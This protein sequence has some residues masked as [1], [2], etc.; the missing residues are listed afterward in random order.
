MH[1]TH[2]KQPANWRC[3]ECGKGTVSSTQRSH[4][5]RATKRTV[6]ANLQPYGHGLR[7]CTR[8]IK[9]AKRVA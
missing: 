1:V 9:K 8:C 6:W 5:F 2:L 3:A 4:S 7:I